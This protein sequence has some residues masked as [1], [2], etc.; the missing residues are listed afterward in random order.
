LTKNQEKMTQ[1]K[2]EMEDKIKK[3]NELLQI[4]R[5]ELKT[6][7]RL[8]E[9]KNAEIAQKE[10]DIRGLKETLKKGRNI[11]KE[12]EIVVHLKDEIQNQNLEISSLKNENSDLLQIND[13]LQNELEKVSNMNRSSVISKRDYRPPANTIRDGTEELIALQ[14][15]VIYH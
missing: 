5:N 4:T 12:S 8:V 2:S 1:N 3:L 9:E 7:R 10:E 6:C 13:L 14:K 15:T 11:N